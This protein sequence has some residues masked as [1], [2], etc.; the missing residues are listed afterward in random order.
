VQP[1]TRASSGDE[2]VAVR[3]Q[4]GG[5]CVLSSLTNR[6]RGRCRVAWKTRFAVENLGVAPERN[7]IP[8]NIKTLGDAR[9]VVAAHSSRSLA[10]RASE[11]IRLYL[12]TLR[13]Q[14]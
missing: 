14:E 13:V 7:A 6:R 5:I 9:G 8:T 4:R 3:R 11:P 2:L 10:T 1:L 12:V